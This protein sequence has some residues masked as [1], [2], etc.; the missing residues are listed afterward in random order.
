MSHG[1][2]RQVTFRPLALHCVA[3][4]RALCIMV[5]VVIDV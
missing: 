1:T 4:V 3:K 2:L 5:C